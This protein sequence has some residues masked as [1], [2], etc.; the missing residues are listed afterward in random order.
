MQK[1]NKFKGIINIGNNKYSYDLTFGYSSEASEQYD[2]TVDRYFPPQPPP[3]FF[4]AA[5]NRKGERYL[6]K[7]IKL[8]PEMEYII[9]LQYCKNRKIS[10]N[11][12]NNKWH[13]DILVCKLQ[14]INDGNII[15]V[16][17]LKEK[18][19]VLTNTNITQLKLIIK[20]KII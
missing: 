2:K 20:S 5:L 12:D 3:G 1:S 10:I 19:I 9:M 17:M 14:D 8:E 18:S 6:S 7:I 15:N 16:D 13:D 11:W 4:D